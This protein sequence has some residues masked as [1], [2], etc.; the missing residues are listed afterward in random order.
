ML[1]RTT[2]HFLYVAIIILI[3]TPS[4]TLDIDLILYCYYQYATYMSTD[5]MTTLIKE[6]EYIVNV[7]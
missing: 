5:F 2:K 3:G 7:R 4:L 6:F 1:L